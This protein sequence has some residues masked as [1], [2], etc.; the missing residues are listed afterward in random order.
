MAVQSKLQALGG[1]MAY[2]GNPQVGSDVID[3]AIAKI[4]LGH[5]LNDGMIIRHDE[6]RNGNNNTSKTK[7]E[8]V[9]TD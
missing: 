4:D 1:Q 9:K 2:P 7:G 6:I 3:R 5:M 8:L